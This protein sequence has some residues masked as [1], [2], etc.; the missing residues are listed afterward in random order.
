MIGTDNDAL[1][2]HPCCEAITA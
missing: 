1:L 2:W